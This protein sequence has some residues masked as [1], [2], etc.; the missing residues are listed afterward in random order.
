[1]RIGSPGPYKLGTAVYVGFVAG[2]VLGALL[3][4]LAFG[5]CLTVGSGAVVDGIMR[6]RGN[7]A[8]G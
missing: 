2:I 1:M 3:G 5:L 7:C 6:I 8:A 4:N